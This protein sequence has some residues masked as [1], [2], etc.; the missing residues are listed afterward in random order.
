MPHHSYAQ[1]R[2]S[3]CLIDCKGDRLKAVIV[4]SIHSYSANL[5]VLAVCI[6]ISTI[7]MVGVLAPACKEGARKYV[8]QTLTSVLYLLTAT[9]PTLLYF[10]LSVSLHRCSVLLYWQLRKAILLFI[11]SSDLNYDHSIHNCWSLLH[12]YHNYGGCLLGSCRVYVCS[13]EHTR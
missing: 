13:N 12:N 11:F 6:V 9:V 5:A 8:I 4:F 10:S 2:K 1:P 3:S 7:A